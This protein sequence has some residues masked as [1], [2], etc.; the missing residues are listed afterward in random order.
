M[1]LKRI[2][3]KEKNKTYLTIT[4]SLHKL[5]HRVGLDVRKPRPTL[6]FFWKFSKIIKS[7]WSH[8]SLTFISSLLPSLF[9]KVRCY[10]SWVR[11]GA[12]QILLCC[13]RSG[14][15]ASCII[16]PIGFFRTPCL[17]VPKADFAQSFRTSVVIKALSA[18]LKT[19]SP[20]L[21]SNPCAVCAHLW[22]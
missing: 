14:T 19:N 18:W 8:S 6:R 2:S 16:E 17:R 11:Q 21:C 10:S 9:P 4:S 22:K 7:L 1:G 20:L 12:L 13:R 15:P 3:K 5:S